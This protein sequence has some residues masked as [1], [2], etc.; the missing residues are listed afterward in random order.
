M[1]ADYPTATRYF[2]IESSPLRTRS[3]KNATSNPSFVLALRLGTFETIPLPERRSLATGVVC[4]RD[5]RM[6]LALVAPA[7]LILSSS[8]I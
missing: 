1:L 2:S 7:T 6:H 4:L 8:G 5:R 3:V